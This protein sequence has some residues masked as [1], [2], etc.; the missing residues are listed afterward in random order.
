MK[1]YRIH[2]ADFWNGFNPELHNM[3]PIMKQVFPNAVF[4][5]EPVDVDICVFSVFGDRHK[6][7][8]ARFKIS[9][10]GEPWVTTFDPKTDLAIGYSAENIKEFRFPLWNF[11]IFEDC[12]YDESKLSKFLEPRNP[13]WNDSIQYNTQ[14]I[15]AVYS[16]KS[17]LRKTAMP[18]L[19]QNNLC[20]SYGCLYRTHMPR[21]DDKSYL[22]Q[23]H[24]FHIAFENQRR[25]GY[26]SEK[27]RDGLL[28]DSLPFY[29]GC[30]TWAKEDFNPDAFFDLSKFNEDEALKAC[31]T[32]VDVMNQHSFCESMR[33][34]PVFKKAP[35]LI[36]L[37]DAI[38]NV[39]QGY[40]V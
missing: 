24:P 11:N 32:M 40:D 7:I 18:I 16:N 30:S 34:A 19:I 9:Y 26:V 20:A 14:P 21:I 23:Q 38:R 17:G 25:E 6:D 12:G 5:N 15:G 37:Y 33:K 1:P 31:H 29:W 27:L 13:K 3:G 8:D 4:I 28:N 22:V 10:Q 35:S 2:F 36:P 39:V